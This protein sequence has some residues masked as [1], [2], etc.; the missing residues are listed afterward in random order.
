MHEIGFVA[1][2]VHRII[3]ILGD[4]GRF[5]GSQLAV[6]SCLV[7]RSVAK[8]AIVHLRRELT[9]GKN[10]VQSLHDADAGHARTLQTF[11]A[12]HNS[13]EPR[14]A[15]VA[16]RAVQSRSPDYLPFAAVT[17]PVRQALVPRKEIPTMYSAAHAQ[18]VS[19]YLLSEVATSGVF[20]GPL[21]FAYGVGGAFT[22]AFLLVAYLVFGRAKRSA[23]RVTRA[24]RFSSRHRHTS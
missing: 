15:D 5:Q 19:E 7:L 21:L 6:K 14:H 23:R 13:F 22:I 2:V 12:G 9:V 20:P 3:H 16:W 18:H 11:A 8:A 1:G 17:S 10:L 4:Q 24:P